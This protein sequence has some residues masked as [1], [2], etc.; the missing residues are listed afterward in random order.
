MIK[1]IREATGGSPLVGCQGLVEELSQ[2]NEYSQ[3]FHHRSTGATGDIPD[4]REL[5]SYVEQTLS[6]IHR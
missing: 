2:V 5:I 3:R 1:K 4:A 6:V